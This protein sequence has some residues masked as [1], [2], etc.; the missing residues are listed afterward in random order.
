MARWTVRGL[1]VLLVGAIAACA[2]D[3]DNPSATVDSAAPP[4][5]NNAEV[6]EPSEVGQIIAL[7]SLTADLIHTL[8]EEKLVGISGSSIL[9]EDE[10]FAG[11][12]VVS[13]GRTEPDLEKIVALQPDLVIGAEGFHDKT[14]DRLAALEVETLTVDVSGWEALRELTTHLA[15]RTGADP[16]P[17]LA[18]YDAC[19]AQ[20]PETA[21]T[22]LVL[23]SRQPLLSPNRD[24][25]A[26]DFL[27]EFNIQNVTAELQGD[28]P[29][30]GY[31]TL[32]E[33]KVLTTDPEV[34]LVVETGENLLE[35]LKGDAFW[36][37]LGATQAERVHM[38][39]YF[40]LVNPGSIA[41][42]EATCAK[43]AE[44]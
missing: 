13:E 16:Q 19:L 20:A 44:L 31:I 23:V 27:A 7:T 37:Q 22:A 35:Q 39:E 12:E 1:G 18:R 14:L 42:I 5:A 8:D 2:S 11:I 25:W 36:S 41:S 4:V 26:G 29:I 28:S 38:F 33:E 6:A 21:P 15:E 10:R 24:S 43:L 34:L 3:R 17:L 9:R 32:S 40:G 30:D